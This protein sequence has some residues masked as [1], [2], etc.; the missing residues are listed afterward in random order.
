MLRE[1]RVKY[2]AEIQRLK[3]IIE[4]LR[5]KLDREESLKLETR[6]KVS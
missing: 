2:Q 1:E 3:F 5:I 4:Q 6:N